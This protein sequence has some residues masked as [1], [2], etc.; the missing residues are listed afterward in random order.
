MPGQQEASQMHQYEF[1][2]ENP[3]AHYEIVQM[4]GGGGFGKIYK[5]TRKTDGKALALKFVEPKD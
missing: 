3:S 1:K 4:I 5:V 2:K